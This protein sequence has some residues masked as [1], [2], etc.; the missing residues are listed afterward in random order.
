MN[1]DELLDGCRQA[2][3]EFLDGSKLTIHPYSRDPDLESLVWDVVRGW[4]NVS[5][6]GPHIVTAITLV[7]TAYN[8][9]T[10]IDTKVQIVLYN[11]IVII[12]DDPA[13]LGATRFG[14]F[15]RMFTGGATESG[16]NLERTFTQI[17]RGIWNHYPRFAASAIVSSSLEFVNANILQ[18]E[19][20][21]MALSSEGAP[22]VEYRRMK[23][24]AAE[25]YAYFIWEKARFPDVRAYIQAIP[26]A[27]RYI[28]HGNDILSFYKE[29]SSGETGTYIVDRAVSEGKS[30]LEVLHEVIQEGIAAMRR[31]RR[32]LGE[33]EAW[34]AWENFACGY[35]GFHTSSPRY[36]LQE[37]IGSVYLIQN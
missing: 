3:Q 36:R 28:N 4:D 7:A 26:D 15:A 34:E 19:T 22:F 16:S 35:I 12:I 21:E 24:G 14:E 17:L 32:I 33:G 1:K 18:N 31:I 25:T 2:L 8:H 11:L 23:D 6:L 13:F 37:V 5:L 20:N 27:I 9:I 29:Q 10:N 30:T